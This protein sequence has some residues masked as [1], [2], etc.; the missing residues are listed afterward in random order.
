[1]NSSQTVQWP[2]YGIDNQRIG[3]LS[4]ADADIF[5]PQSPDRL[6]SPPNLLSIDT[7]VLSQRVKW[8]GREADQSLSSSAEVKSVW[9]Y[10]YTP[11]YVSQRKIKVVLLLDCER[12]EL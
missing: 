3:V 7:G 12:E 8:L 6:W 4:P 2:Q 1:M 11:P 5:P 10:V 9:S